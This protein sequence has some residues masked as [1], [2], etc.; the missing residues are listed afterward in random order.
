MR[1]RFLPPS[2]VKKSTTSDLLMVRGWW[3][4]RG[5]L[6]DEDFW[7]GDAVQ[8]GMIFDIKH[9][10]LHDGPGIRTTVFFKGC[11]L[12]CWWCHNPESQR[13][14]PELLLHPER[15]IGCDRC[16]VAC[17]SGAIDSRDRCGSCGACADACPA[18]AR[19][20]AGK[21]MTVD[22]V[23]AEIRKDS[24]FYDE[25]GGGVTFS[26]GEPL[27]QP[28]FLR[29]LLERCRAEEIHTVVD[30]SGFAQRDLLLSVGRLTDLILYDLKHMDPDQHERLTGVSN[31]LI[32]DNL[33][34][35]TSTGA[36]LRIRVPIIPGNNDDLANIDATAQFVASLTGVNEIDIL[37]YHGSAAEKYRKMGLPYRLHELTPPSDLHMQAIAARL[38]SYGL[39]VRIGG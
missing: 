4:V 16:R 32:L 24:A 19:V 11:P 17:P 9:Y 2:A 7:W 25:S 27:C 8:Q 10:A 12:S 30:T 1:H 28:A 38:R 13:T 15:C 34:T 39:S 21:T 22:E 14:T 26:G 18:D 6:S 29:A 36:R 5:E 3:T 33:R 37:P 31:A 35:L 20:I 23:M